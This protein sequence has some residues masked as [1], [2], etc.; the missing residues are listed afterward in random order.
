M[1][2]VVFIAACI[3]V[4]DQVTKWLVVQYIY[5]AAPVTVIPG[6]FHLVH[7]RNTGAAWGLFRGYN[8]VLAVVSVLTIVG[9]YLYRH[10]FGINRPVAGVA[11]GLIVGGISGNFMDRLRHQSVVDFLDFFIGDRHWP[12]FNVADSAICIGVALYIIVSWRNDLNAQPA[13]ANSTSDR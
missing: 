12:A 5:E 2:R 11:L 13:G 8:W 4:L 3:A 1:K 6:F 7:W 10:S 9:L